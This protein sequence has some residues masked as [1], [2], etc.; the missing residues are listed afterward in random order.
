MDYGGVVAVGAALGGDWVAAVDE[1]VVGGLRTIALIHYVAAILIGCSGSINYHHFFRQRLIIRIKKRTVQRKI[2]DIR[3][4]N[5]NR[6]IYDIS[7][8]DRR[9]QRYNRSDISNTNIHLL[10]IFIN[11]IHTLLFTFMSTFRSST[12]RMASSMAAGGRAAGCRLAT[13]R[14]EILTRT[15][16]TIITIAIITTVITRLIFAAIFTAI[17]IAFL[18]QFF[19]DTLHVFCVIKFV[20][21]LIVF[22][23]A[24]T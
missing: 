22:L 2:I 9:V 8:V 15:A 16:S 18:S 11:I 23:G 13:L 12:L 10:L 21:L 24:R 14:T 5:R 6:H 7:V 4:V 17:G 3:V 1:G 20:A 19:T